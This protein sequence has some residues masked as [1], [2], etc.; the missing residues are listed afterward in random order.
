MAKTRHQDAIDL[1]RLLEVGCRT[2][3]SWLLL[4]TAGSGQK[5]DATPAMLTPGLWPRPA[6][7]ERRANTSA[8]SRRE[9][10]V[11]FLGVRQAGARPVPP[12]PLTIL[13]GPWFLSCDM[14][15]LTSPLSVGP[16]CCH[17]LSINHHQGHASLHFSWHLRNG[18]HCPHLQTESWSAGGGLVQW[19]HRDLNPSARDSNAAR[20]ALGRTWR[21]HSLLVV[22]VR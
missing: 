8:E 10:A 22:A 15:T 6:H 5:A 9:R 2:V 1:S 13:L 11:R 14:G 18:P 21:A 12:I 20:F 7:R 19:G 16:G 17:R 3:G 4:V